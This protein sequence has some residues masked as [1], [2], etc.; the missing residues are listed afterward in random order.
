MLQTTIIS[1]LHIGHYASD[2]QI[3][4]GGSNSVSYAS[5]TVVHN[6]F[7][8]ISPS[9]SLPMDTWKLDARF[10]EVVDVVG[11]TTTL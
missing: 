6:S 5:I 7:S 2:R 1:Y 3:F 10:M 8:S 4:I 11:V 9:D